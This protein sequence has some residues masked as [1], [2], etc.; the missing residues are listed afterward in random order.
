MEPEPWTELRE[1]MGTEFSFTLALRLPPGADVASV[2][3]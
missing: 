1:V 2:Y 3:P